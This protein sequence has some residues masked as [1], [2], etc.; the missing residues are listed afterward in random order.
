L[1]TEIW[2]S[3]IE[4]VAFDVA[5]APAASTVLAISG[6]IAARPMTSPR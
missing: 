2:A 4:A 5:L 3:R 1:K 6:A